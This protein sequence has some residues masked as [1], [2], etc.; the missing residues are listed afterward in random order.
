MKVINN[1]F[2]V[3]VELGKIK[4]EKTNFLLSGNYKS[5]KKDLIDLS[6]KGN[7][8][9]ISEIFSVL[10]SSVSN[11][12]NNYRSNGV[13]NFNG[14]LKGEL[15]SKKTL[16]FDVDFNAENSSLEDLENNGYYMDEKLQLA[17]CGDWCIGR[18][19]ES[20]YLSGCAL[21]LALKKNIKWK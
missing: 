10:P 3:E 16:S 4:L 5:H 9:E 2:S 11:I 15:N 18:H 17:A 6:L 20:A 1:P 13:L 8:I 12:S 7:K 14:H 19:V 21:S